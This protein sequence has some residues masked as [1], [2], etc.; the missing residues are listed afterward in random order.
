MVELVSLADVLEKLVYV[1]TNPVKD[2]LVERVHHWPG[3]KFV[4]ALLTGRPMHARRPVHF[5]RDEGPMPAHIELTVGLPDHPANA[6]LLAELRR[7]ISEVENA[8]AS[9]RLATGRG[10]VGRRGVL[11]QSWRDCPTTREP[12]RNLRPR[13]AARSKWARIAAL[14]RNRE[15]EATYREM[16]ERWRA[17]EQVTFPYG[18][19]WLRRF[20][21]V[22]V[23]T[24]A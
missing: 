10:V 4:Q 6:G 20:A 1:A 14:Q 3:P 18:T 5:F 22:P 13:V 2:G 15:W 9:K 8:C 19:Y 12:R 17:G 11:R 7:R 16:R 23:L 21:N 24:P